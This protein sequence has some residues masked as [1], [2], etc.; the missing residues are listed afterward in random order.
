MYASCAYA[1][2]ASEDQALWSTVRIQLF[3]QVL[4]DLSNMTPLIRNMIGWKL[5]I[6]RATH[7][8]CTLVHLLTQFAKWREISKVS[9]LKCVPNCLLQLKSNFFVQHNVYIYIFIFTIFERFNNNGYLLPGVTRQLKVS[10]SQVI[11]YDYYVHTEA[12]KIVIS[13][14]ERMFFRTIREKICAKYL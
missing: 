5:T 14:H 4:E 12:D 9:T 10:E 1:R 7:D 13:M 6:T 3:P 11:S 8:A 2:V